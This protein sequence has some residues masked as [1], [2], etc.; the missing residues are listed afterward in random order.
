M[1]FNKY[2]YLSIGIFCSTFIFVKYVI[3]KKEFK[4]RK[5]KIVGDEDMGFGFIADNYPVL[6]IFINKKNINK[7]NINKLIQNPNIFKQFPKDM[8]EGSYFIISYD[9]KFKE[10][11]GV[12]TFD[13]FKEIKH[14]F[15]Q[16][17]PEELLLKI[18][19]AKVNIEYYKTR[20]FYAESQLNFFKKLTLSS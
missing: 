9:E 8:P 7:N 3:N 17:T 4:D 6:T 19:N 10:Y 13:E 18:P 16:G 2:I 12:I 20:I 15:I 1:I 14:I 5:E 11:T